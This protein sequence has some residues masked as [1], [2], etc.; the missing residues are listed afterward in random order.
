MKRTAG[1]PPSR[2]LCDNEAAVRAAT[3]REGAPVALTGYRLLRWRD[4][5]TPSLAILCWKRS[6][7]G[8]GFVSASVDR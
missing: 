8:G 3:V 6:P 4:G 5:G 1:G 2:E 7:K